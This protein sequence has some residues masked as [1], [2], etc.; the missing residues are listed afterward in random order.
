[1]KNRFA[2]FCCLLSLVT[3]Y[4]P[5][6]HAAIPKVM[7]YQGILKD[8]SGNFLTGTYSMTFRVYAVQTGG[9]AL[10][11]ETQS[12]VSVSSGRFSVQL[13]SVTPLNLSFNQDHWLSLQVGTDSEMSPRVRLTSVGYAYM[14]EQVVNGFTQAQHDSLTHRNIEGVMANTTNI[15][16]TNFKLDAYT[17]ASANSMGDLIIDT[18]SDATGINPTGSSGYT[19]RGSPDYD[20]VA[21]AGGIDASAVLMLHANGTD[22]SATFTDS[23]QTPKTLTANGNAQI[24]TAQSKFGGASALFDGSGDYLSIPDS[25]DWDFGTGDFTI[26]FW[27]RFNTVGTQVFVDR[28]AGDIAVRRGSDGTLKFSINGNDQIVS[29]TWSPS[30]NVWYHI[31]AVRSGTSAYLFVNGVQLGSTGTSSHNITGTTG[32]A[33]GARGDGYTPIDGWMDEVRISK[34]IARWTSNFTPPTG[35]YTTPSG[36]ATVA[37]IAFSETVTPKEAMVIASETLNTGTITYSVS[38]DNGTT[39]TP[40]TKETVCNISSQPSGTQIKWKAAITGNAELESIA[41]AL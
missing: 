7:T 16:K 26:D 6:V 18:F 30:V 9:T 2:L 21:G 40:C 22:A 1:M 25:A 28:N 20:V 4:L 15:A 37:S 27:V 35:E 13:G 29:A 17:K 41:V 39:W 36:S 34:G 32:M 38:R 19:W 31:A 14:A 5:L 8:A 11:S 24:D 3:C 33:V 12:A 10:W 23:S